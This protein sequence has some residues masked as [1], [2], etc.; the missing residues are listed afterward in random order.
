MKLKSS[1][2]FFH[3]WGG[4]RKMYKNEIETL[5]LFLMESTRSCNYRP[6]DV[7]SKVKILGAI[8]T[9]HIRGCNACSIHNLKESTV[10]C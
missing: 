7:L 2:I 8:N 1:S 3:K 4:E 9:F 6:T 5:T 10:T